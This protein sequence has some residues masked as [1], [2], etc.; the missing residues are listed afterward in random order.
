LSN[1]DAK[2]RIQMREDILDIQRQLGITAVY[3]THDQEEALVIS[4]RIAVMNFGVVQQIGTPWDIYRDPANEF[5]ATFVGNM[6]IYSSE[7]IRNS[8]TEDTR[9]RMNIPQDRAQGNVRV[10]F[11]PE[12]ARILPPKE[13][14]SREDV[15]FNGNVE[16]TLFLGSDVIYRIGI[17]DG[18]TLTVNEYVSKRSQLRTEGDEITA[19]V[20][21]SHLMFFDTSDG[22]RI[23]EEE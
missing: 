8:V 6:N 16:K 22:A 21:R 14:V 13:K 2:L 18:I 19:V 7:V 17:G 4:D 10:A 11:R 12:D 23:R 5:V 15:A 9:S 20:P 1:L 3:V